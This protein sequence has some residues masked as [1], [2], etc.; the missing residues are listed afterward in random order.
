MAAIVFVAL[1][2]QSCNTSGCTE[3]QSAL[4][5]AGF[6]SSSGTAISVSGFDIIGVGAPGDSALYTAGQAR[7]EIYLP[8]RS[9]ASSTA[10]LFNY[11]ADSVTTVTDR[12]EFSYTSEP[13]FASEECGA[14]YRYRITG[15]S[16]TRNLIDSIGITDS[17]ITNFNA[18]RIHIYFRTA[19][20]SEQ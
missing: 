2:P 17:L 1:L 14:M 20:S 16:Y 11:Q 12:V 6:Y 5:L 15:L 10:F 3:N 4:P 7:S 18:Q 13:Y 19:E 9:T 8:F